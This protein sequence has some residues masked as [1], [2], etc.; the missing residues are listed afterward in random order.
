MRSPSRTVESARHSC[1][2]LSKVARLATFFLVAK[3]A[4]GSQE[5]VN[6]GEPRLLPPGFLFEVSARVNGGGIFTNPVVMIKW[7][8]HLAGGSGRVVWREATLFR[9]C[10]LS[11][12]C[13]L[14]WRGMAV[15]IRLTW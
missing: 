2:R 7:R 3:L 14:Q 15:D 4:A 11:P 6:C 9:C 10:W 5:R 13:A 1:R 8:F 12:E